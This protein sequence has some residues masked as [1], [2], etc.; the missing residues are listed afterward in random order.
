MRKDT[1]R[2][3]PLVVALLLILPLILYVGSYLALVVPEGF[4]V[5]KQA[6]GFTFH[7]SLHYRW[8]GESTAPRVFWPLEQ[9]DRTLR[10]GRWPVP[11]QF[12]TPR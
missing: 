7:V 12:L 8:G 2:A 9:L 5:Q 4:I 11:Q 6:G 3:T 1:S 10:P